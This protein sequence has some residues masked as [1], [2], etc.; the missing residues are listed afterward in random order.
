MTAVIAQLHGLTTDNEW[1]PMRADKTGSAPRRS[2]TAWTYAGAAGGITD[3]TAVTLKAAGGVKTAVYLT[4][5]Q[6]VNKS[7]TATEVVVKSDTTVLWRGYAAANGANPVHVSFPDPLVAGN[8]TALT[9]AC[10]T[11]STATIV[12]A[13]GYTDVSYAV[14]QD[15]GTAGEGIYDDNGDPLTDDS[16]IQLT[17]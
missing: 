5:L 11:T 15:L 14:L 8:N 6:V 12:N 3:T 2:Y 1:V 10:V 16:G 17:L 9:F 13:Q 7:A 4:G